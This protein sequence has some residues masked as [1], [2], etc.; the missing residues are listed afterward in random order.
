MP[1][2][3][4]EE[5]VRKRLDLLRE[6]RELK[7][8]SRACKRFGISRKTYYKFEK[9]FKASGEDN[10]SL[11]DKSKRPHR[12]RK[13][14]PKKMVKLI[15]KIRK[16][17]NF[18][19]AR[20]RQLLLK[21]GRGR[22]PSVRTI[23]GILARHGLAQKWKHPHK[24]PLRKFIVPAP[25]E[26]VQID[27]KFV[28][29]PVEGKRCCQF[30]A[31]D[32]ASRLRFLHF[33]DELTQMEAASFLEEVVAAFP[34]KIHAVQTDNGVEFTNLFVT[35]RA[36]LDKEPKLHPFDEGCAAHGIAHRLIPPHCPSFN[37]HAERSHRIDEEEFYRRVRCRSLLELVREGKRWMRYYNRFRMHGGIGY[38]TPMQKLRALQE[39]GA[40]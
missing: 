4:Q 7:N 38:L 39:A 5:K 12:L 15:I 3:S 33:T 1:K 29:Y 16:K 14:T 25:G 19:P 2:L 32:C 36:G 30:T 27:V 11:K 22:A 23:A 9:R 18:G 10:D 28:P 24:K 6:A 34:F 40:G 13:P 20:I 31:I 37:G 17:T 21:Q 8:V 26:L 35:A